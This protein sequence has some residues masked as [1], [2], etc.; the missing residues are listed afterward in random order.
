MVRNLHLRV[1]YLLI[2][3]SN[4]NCVLIGGR[5]SWLYIFW[6]LHQTT[7]PAAAS[8]N[9]FKLYIFWFLHQ[10]TTRRNRLTENH[11]CISFDSYI[12]P[13]PTRLT[14]AYR[15]VVY[16]LIP[17]SN[18]NHYTIE[19]TGRVLYIFWFLHQTTTMLAYC[20]QRRCCISFDS[21]IKPQPSRQPPLSIC[22]VYLLI[23]TSN[24]NL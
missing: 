20:L 18:H 24:H 2:P 17:T 11:G 14:A 5:A 3:T 16:L 8:C 19:H 6:F 22:V 4:H 1:V 21:Y 12:K 15:L 23:P 9:C 7:T 10:T 13:Q